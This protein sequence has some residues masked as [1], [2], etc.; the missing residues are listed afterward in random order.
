[1]E[2]GVGHERAGSVGSCG[3][4]YG[5]TVRVTGGCLHYLLCIM[6]FHCIKL[7]CI[8]RVREDIAFSKARFCMRTVT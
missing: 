1:M 6:L 2:T 4:D 5:I 7:E 3:T 8:Y